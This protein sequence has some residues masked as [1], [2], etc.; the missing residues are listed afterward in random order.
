MPE[1]TFHLP[2][3]FRWGVATAAHQVEGSNVNND[4][5]MWEQ[6][7]GCIKRGD[8]SGLACN[9]W[10]DAEADL[11]QAAALGVDTLRLSVEWSRVEPHP[12]TFDQDALGRYAEILLGLRRR[13]IEP[14]VTLHHFTNPRW[15]ADQG[16][17]EDRETVGLFSRFVSRVTVALGEHCHL[18][19]TINEPNV[20]AYRGYLDGSWPPGKS[21]FGAAIDVIRNL[22]LGHA[23]AYHVIHE[24]QPDARVGLAHN[25]RVFDPAGSRSLLDRL[26]AWMIDRAYNK[27]VLTALERGLWSPPLGFGLALK[28]R[29]TLD[30]IGLNYHTRDLVAFDRT[31]PKDYF[32]RRLHADDGILLDGG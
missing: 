30:W 3:D 14:M 28:L 13:G 24:V 10:K 17:W 21:D 6:Q 8:T 22:L 7:E 1:A 16:G 5:W 2:E 15:L 12:G 4:W 18:W 23:A 9:W 27:A 11:D 29:Q 20:Y 32:T 31:R 19:C 25:M 26:V